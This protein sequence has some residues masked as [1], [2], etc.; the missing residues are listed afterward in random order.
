MYRVYE[1]SDFDSNTLQSCCWLYEYKTGVEYKTL[2]N[3]G[4]SGSG[5]QSCWA[6]T[7]HCVSI[8]LLLHELRE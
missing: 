8:M 7:I 6:V 3:A 1:K 4:G 5:N 2:I